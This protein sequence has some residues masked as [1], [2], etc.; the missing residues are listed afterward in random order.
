M[1]ELAARMVFSPSRLTYQVKVLER[2]GWVLRHPS[3]DDKRVSYAVLTATGLE[4]FRGAD[5][6]HIET[7]QRLFTA[8]LGEDDLHVIARVFTRLRCR[9]EESRAPAGGGRAAAPAAD[10]RPGE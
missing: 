7:V 3:P 6:H 1:G 8:D 9:L 2:R 10:H 4:A 5:R